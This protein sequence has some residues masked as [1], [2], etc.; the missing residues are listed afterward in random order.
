MLEVRTTRKDSLAFSQ[1]GRAAHSHW[2][3]VSQCGCSSWRLAKI[4][5]RLIAGFQ[6]SPAVQLKLTAADLE[7]AHLGFVFESLFCGSVGRL[8]RVPDG[9]PAEVS[10]HPWL[11]ELEKS[12]TARASQQSAV[13]GSAAVLRRCTFEVLSLWV[14]FSQ[15]R[16]GSLSSPWSLRSVRVVWC[17]QLRVM[18]SH[19]RSR[20]IRESPCFVRETGH[21]FRPNVR[22]KLPLDQQNVFTDVQQ[23]PLDLY[24]SN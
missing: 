23:R 15:T 24:V 11:L 13:G 18:C 14:R 5:L 1:A 4:L 7:A 22:K 20:R 10:R 19:S 16:L 17:R 8:S 2:C 3:R 12:S 6:A 21:E 9:R